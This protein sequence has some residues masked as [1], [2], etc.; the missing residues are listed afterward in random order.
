M[1]DAPAQWGQ[2]V[3]DASRMPRR[4]V[5]GVLGASAGMQFLM[6]GHTDD[7]EFTP[8]S[9][10]GAIRCQRMTPTYVTSRARETGSQLG[11]LPEVKLEKWITA[12][13]WAAAWCHRDR[14]PTRE[15]R[16]TICRRAGIR[17]MRGWRAC[18]RRD[19][20]TG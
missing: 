13:S 7:L 4:S 5:A 19:G 2:A 17:V 20:C 16:P 11:T 18:E 15:C 12:K 8:G 10:V 6:R 9:K 1:T 3:C 14:V